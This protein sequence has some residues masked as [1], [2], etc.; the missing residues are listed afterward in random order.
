VKTGLKLLAVRAEQVL[1]DVER[2][3]VDSHDPPTIYF[4]A[5]ALLATQLLR[6]RLDELE[7]GDVD[8]DDEEVEQAVAL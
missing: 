2:A 7:T 6:D 5:S 3:A 8:L 4:A 1:L